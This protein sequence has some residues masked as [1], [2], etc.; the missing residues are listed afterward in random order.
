MQNTFDYPPKSSRSWKPVIFDPTLIIVPRA[1]DL[2]WSIIPQNEARE[3]E[4]RR[5]RREQHEE[6]TPIGRLDG[7]SFHYAEADVDVAARI[8]EFISEVTGEA[9]ARSWVRAVLRQRLDLVWAR[10]QSN[11]EVEDEG[12]NLRY[13]NTVKL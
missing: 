8:K 9:P 12:R 5:W 11:G 13:N 4:L 3:G 6:M 10:D 2:T 1:E 7:R